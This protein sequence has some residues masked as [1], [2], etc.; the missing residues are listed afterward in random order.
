MDENRYQVGDLFGNGS[1][2]NNNST[3]SNQPDYSQSNYNQPDYSQSNYNQ[4]D[5]SQSNYNQT[6]PDY[7]NYNQQQ[8]NYSQ[9][10]YNQNN[11]S[12]TANSGYQQP[13]YGTPQYNPY[14]MQ[15]L[16]PPLT[17]G[18][19][20]LTYVLTCIPCVG[21]IMLFIWAFSKTE[22]KSKSNWAKA[23]LIVTAV[24][25]VLSLIFG[26]SMASAMFNY[27]SHYSRII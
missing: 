9:Y 21:L 6:Q 10:N 15:D 1:D 23:M 22:P 18:D 27:M 17:V 4:T 8:P 5:Y 11:Y 12:Q 13:N 2:Q 26:A 20:V 24:V 16:E 7:S 25:L 3:G 14:H 19:W